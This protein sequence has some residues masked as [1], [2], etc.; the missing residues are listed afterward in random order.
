MGKTM[1]D[2]L[3]IAAAS[4]AE[5]RDWVE[6]R[7]GV[8][9]AG[10]GSHASMGTHNALW[11]MGDCYLEVIAVDP[12]GVRPERPRWFGFDDPEVQARLAGG[13]CLVTWAVSVS[14]IAALHAPVP[15]H[16]PEG[17][18]RDDLRWQVVLPEAAALPLGGAWPLTIRWTEGLHPA[19]RLPDQGLRLERLEIAGAGVDEAQAALGSVEG[20]VVF[21]PGDGPVRLSAV[22]GTPGGVVSLSAAD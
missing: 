7:L 4:L 19:K 5:G 8:S 1:L 10:G 11:G 12:D 22:I 13:P 2:H 14:D 9:A 3:V 21:A 6:A 15:C 16:P 20:P 18:A 17:F